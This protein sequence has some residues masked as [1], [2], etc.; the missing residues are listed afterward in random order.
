MKINKRECRKYADPGFT[1]KKND[2]LLLIENINHIVRTA[3]KNI[4]G[5]RVLILYFYERERAADNAAPEYILFQCRDD[6]ITLQKFEDGTEKWL[7]AS[8]ENLGEHYA[9]FHKTCAFYRKKD[10]ERVTRFCK[11]SYTDSF[12]ALD[13]LQ[14]Y[15]MQTRLKERIKKRERKII[16][17]MQSVPPVPRALKG[18]IHREILPHY[19]YY[20]Y[21]RS[22][23]PMQG[24]CTACRHDILVSGVKHC[25][26][27]KCPRCGKSVTFKA[28]GRTKRIFDRITVQVLQRINE[29]E[30]L[31]RIFKIT[32][33]IRDC[34]DPK[35]YTWENARFFIRW[36]ETGSANIS[37]YYYSYNRGMFTK[38]HE[39]ER[40]H[41]PKYQYNYECDVCGYLYCDNINNALAGT[42]WQ[43]SQ[44]E[45]FHRIDGEPLEV[46]PYIR[47][48]NRYPAIEYLVKFGLFKLVSQI[49]YRYDCPKVINKDGKNLRETLGIGPEDLPLLQ[50]INV[51]AYEFLL[52]NELKNQGVRLDEQFFTW[53]RQRDISSNENL[54]IAL[55]YSTPGKLMRYIDE[56]FELL[57]NWINRHG[58][59]RYKEP[60]NI[61]S[62][63]KDYLLMGVKLG[64]DFTDSFVL[65]PKN[66]PEA[67][68]LASILIDVKK[69]EIY[70]KQIQ[71]AY[72]GLLEQYRF[73]KNGL[74][75]IPPK[76]AKEIVV[77]G[78]FLHHCV[79]SYVERVAEGKCVILFIRETSDIEKPFYTLEIHNGQIVQIQGKHHCKPTPKVKKF[80][81]LWKNK[82]LLPAY[83]AEAA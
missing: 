64:Y 67:H 51:N 36:D 77:E 22:K 26:K 68:D 57:K 55:K 20:I 16:E 8:L 69:K 2:G 50:K 76:T 21:K 24:Y 35:L 13:S 58:V 39:G 44:L 59:C 37:P 6:Y 34:R 32:N 17:R 41:F 14:K 25:G 56:K 45:Q 11:R 42:P 78:H 66:L 62:D 30:L 28:N 47:A 43:Y 19:I 40:P 74:T 61:L 70:N 1:F 72:K 15:I 4:S 12:T 10:D 29:T 60:N 3:I 7:S 52:Y 5:K 23:K 65:F 49:V 54:L 33:K 73:T 9:Y 71:E 38:W 75:L 48:Y 79:N 82:K 63:Y 81:E 27:G 83:R 80:L 31:L 53:C 18:W 46:I